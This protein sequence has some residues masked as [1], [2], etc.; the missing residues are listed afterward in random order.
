MCR[1]TP[2]WLPPPCSVNT[3]WAY[4]RDGCVAGRSGFPLGIKVGSLDD[5]AFGTGCDWSHSEAPGRAFLAKV[6]AC[7]LNSTLPP[8]VTRCVTLGKARPSLGLRLLVGQVEVQIHAPMCLVSY[9][10][11]TAVPTSGRHVLPTDL[12]RH[13]CS[14]LW[15]FEEKGPGQSERHPLHFSFTTSKMEKIRPRFI[16]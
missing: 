7:H 13:G 14:R 11:E 5:A 3:M 4:D 2:S 1:R 6:A 8:P 15:C 16:L 10:R 12:Q 9:T